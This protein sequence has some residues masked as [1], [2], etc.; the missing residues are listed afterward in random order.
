M[1]LGYARRWDLGASGEGQLGSPS[2]VVAD[3]PGPALR[4]EILGP[5][6]VWRGDTCLA[7][8]PVQPRVVLAVLA[9]HANRPLRREQLIDAIWGEAA[10][11]Y[12]VNLV[13]KHISSLRRALEPVR[14]ARSP[15][16]LLTWTDIGY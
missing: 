1:N 2:S 5:L 7:L 6:Q 10:P 4:L 9:L 12:A 15:S 8:G 16:Q 14:S 13:Q 3:P 11:A